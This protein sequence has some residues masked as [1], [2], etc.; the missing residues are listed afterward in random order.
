MSGT[1]L[2]SND[3]IAPRSLQPVQDMV[4]R[5]LP[6]VAA[7]QRVRDDLSTVLNN[8]TKMILR[9]RARAR[10]RDNVKVARSRSRASGLKR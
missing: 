8:L 4:P 2:F 6:F 3:D 7:L 5:R 1:Q 9:E 10:N